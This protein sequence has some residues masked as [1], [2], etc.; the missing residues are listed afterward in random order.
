MKI[1]VLL[2]L[3]LGFAAHLDAAPVPLKYTRIDLSDG[4]TLLNVV[5]KSYDPDT[6]KLLV[7]ADGKAVLFPVKLV[8][9]P[10][11][12]RLKKEAPQA[13]ATNSVV[14]GEKPPAIASPPNK[15]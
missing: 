15:K 8:P 1:P 7:T 2:L 4:R 6:G 12:D 10:F 9:Q 3:V 11:R 13:G 5:V 14:P